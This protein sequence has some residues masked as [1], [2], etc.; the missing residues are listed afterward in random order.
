MSQISLNMIAFI[1]VI[2][3]II[4]LVIVFVNVSIDFILMFIIND[5]GIFV[6]IFFFSLKMGLT[7]RINVI[8]PSTTIFQSW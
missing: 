3:I 6:D 5:I 4:L 7:I 1:H 2:F 8:I